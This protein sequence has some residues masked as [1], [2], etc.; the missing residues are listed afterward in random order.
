MNSKKEYIIENLELINNMI[1]E[2]RP[3]FE[4]ARVLGVKYETL[5]KHLKA[6]GIDYAG[7]QSGKGIPGT[8]EKKP[9]EEYLG[10]GKFIPASRLRNKLIESGLKEN[11]CECCGLDSW[12]GKKIPLE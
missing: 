7:N 11:K 5:N 8:N 2:N 12:M 9:V 4:I 1:S 6:L 10:T 3:K